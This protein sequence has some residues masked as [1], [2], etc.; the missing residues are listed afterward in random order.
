M[1]KV[2]A[3]QPFPE[4]VAIGSYIKEHAA[5]Q[6]TIALFGSEPEIC[7]YSARHC[8]SSYL[9][10]YPLMEPQK[11]A[12]QM[13]NEMMQ[14]VRDARPRFL[15]YVNDIHSWG[16]KAALEENREFVE[17]AWAYA[18]RDYKVVDE[19]AIAGDPEHMW[20]DH[21]YLYVFRRTGP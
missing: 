13:Q 5:E 9:Y 21:A 19:V 14:Q 15:V 12:R 17:M 20:G 4:A 18:Q 2:Q 1:R 11:F 8:A 3:K 16:T 10:V 7:F 6:D